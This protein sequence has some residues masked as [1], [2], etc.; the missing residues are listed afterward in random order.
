MTHPW[1]QKALRQWNTSETGVSQP[2]SHCHLRPGWEIMSWTRNEDCRHNSLYSL[3]P[4]ATGEYSSGLSGLAWS[5]RPLWYKQFL[6]LVLDKIR[7]ELWKKNP[8]LRANPDNKVVVPVR[9]QEGVWDLIASYTCTRGLSVADQLL[10]YALPV[11]PLPTSD[12]S[13]LIK[14]KRTPYHGDCS[15]T[16]R[17]R[18]LVNINIIVMYVTY[19]VPSSRSFI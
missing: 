9:N 2:Y 16:G 4:S 13:E 5:S 6:Q 14:P 7:G 19:F 12:T 15:A 1:E 8:G 18:K 10:P 11:S 17:S 3:A